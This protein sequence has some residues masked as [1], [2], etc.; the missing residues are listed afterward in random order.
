MEKLPVKLQSFIDKYEKEG[1][2]KVVCSAKK[3][4]RQRKINLV[5][6]K[7]ASCEEEKRKASLCSDFLVFFGQLT[8][9]KK[10]FQGLQYR[11]F[12]SRCFCIFVFSFS[13]RKN[14]FFRD[15][16]K[17]KKFVNSISIRNKNK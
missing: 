17:Q 11:V 1:L 15:K 9:K 3:F 16:T 14:T 10:H 7:K 13:P 6:R 4:Y 2:R 12:F 8:R 5:V